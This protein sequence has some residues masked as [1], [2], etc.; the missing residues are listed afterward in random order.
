MARGPVE[1]D[2]SAAREPLLPPATFLNESTCLTVSHSQEF[3]IS[4][5]IEWSACSVMLC[6]FAQWR[7]LNVAVLSQTS[8]HL[9]FTPQPQQLLP[10]LT[11]H[12]M[13]QVRDVP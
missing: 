11:G 13:P 8:I 2:E 12:Q 1:S 10:P 5:M 6:G 4:R 7:F 9:A 3:F